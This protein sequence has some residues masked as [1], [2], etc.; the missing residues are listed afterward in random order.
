MRIR[1]SGIRWLAV[2]ALGAV[3][4]S[5]LVAQAGPPAGA[6]VITGVVQDEAGRPLA[7]ARVRI[8]DGARGGVEA[9]TDSLG[10]FR[11]PLAGVAAQS[12]V[13]RRVGYAPDTVP[14]AAVPPGG[15][16]ALVLRRL[17]QPM[18]VILVAGRRDLR[19]PLAGFYARR[20]RGQGRYFT[21]EEI[22]RLGA[23]RLSD[24]LRGVPGLRLESRRGGR[25]T[26]RIRGAAAPPLVWLDGAPLGSME[27]DFDAFDARTFAGVEVY[28]GPATV[29]PEFG[30]GQ[31]TSTAGGTIVLWSREGVVGTPRRRRGAPSPFGVMAAMLARGELFTADQVE[32][33][34]RLE[35]G[36]TLA[37]LYPDSLL[38]AR[39]AGATE[40]EFVVDAAGQV[41]GDAVGVMW[42]T[43]P[44]FG[45]AARRAILG[46]PFV[47]A[48]RGGRT[49][50]Q[51][52]RWPFRFDPD[53]GA[54]SRVP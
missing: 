32:M 6:P 17:V 2:A 54:G 20:A 42:A 27:L 18:P 22:E 39:V 45:E 23:P 43:H 51:L 41:L 8:A 31:R 24:L 40:V 49:V 21:F 29:P 53:D 15:G 19:G 4:A 28:A 30:G 36:E 34:A 35:A 44:A 47:P 16:I 9:E 3:T 38:A 12:L 14:V 37:P 26:M 50:P 1:T 52:V 7:G 48:R 25:S 10:R 46:R 33:P 5:V 11:V 13:A